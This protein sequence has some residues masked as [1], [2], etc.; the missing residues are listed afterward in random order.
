MI[1]S[2]P[3]PVQ[4]PAAFA[5]ERTIYEKPGYLIRRLQQ[6]AVTVFLDETERF[7]ITPLQYGALAAIRAHP[8]IDQ[9]RVGYAIGLDRTTVMVV[10]RRLHARRLITRVTG[11]ADRRSRQLELTP[12]G[13]RLLD[14]MLPGTERAQ[15]RML[16]GLTQKQQVVFVRMLKRLVSINNDVSRIPVTLPVARPR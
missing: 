1:I 10:V 11:S 5:L 13:A 2:M 6:L 14:K 15:R 9:L 3:S 4:P 12:A 7:A 8:G 16:A